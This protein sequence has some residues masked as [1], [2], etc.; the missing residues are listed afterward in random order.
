V[1]CAVHLQRQSMVRVCVGE[2]CCAL[3][4]AVDD[5]RVGEVCYALTEAVDDVCVCRRGVLRTYTGSR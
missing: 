2:V 3:T 5:G 4:E 1:R